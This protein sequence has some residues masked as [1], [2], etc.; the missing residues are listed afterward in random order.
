MRLLGG[1]SSKP[2]EIGLKFNRRILTKLARGYN[3][4]LVTG[5]NGKTTT[6]SMI[7]NIFRRAG[8]RVIN[9]SSGANMPGGIVTCFAKHHKFFDHS[10]DK[11]AVIEVDE[12]YAKHVTAWIK[13]KAFVITNI[14]Q[15]QIDR[16]GDVQ[17][18]KNY[19]V[20]AIKNMP[21]TTLIVNADQPI[22]RDLPVSNHCIYYGSNAVLANETDEMTT[23]FATL[24]FTIGEEVSLSLKNSTIQ[25]NEQSLSVGV[26]GF[27][28]V[29]NALCAYSVCS[30]F[31]ISHEII[32]SSLAEQ[33]S[34][35]GRFEVMQMEES[36]L[37]MLLIKNPA[38]ANQC[39]D[40]VAL[41]N[42]NVS[43][44]IML[45]DN[46]GDG[47]DISW[48]DDT[49]FEKLAKMD[50]SNVIAGGTRAEDLAKRLRLAGLENIN[51]YSEFDDILEAIKGE[52]R[53]VYA[54]V[55][56]TAMFSFRKYLASKGY[57]KG[58]L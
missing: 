11:F 25:I 43:F 12:A 53:R 6:C 18:T 50:Y 34:K 38:G 10:T 28:N 5:T 46:A 3:I 22:L 57:A 29:Y 37:V 20:D 55:S 54:L 58:N 40:T 9:N 51:V 26:P 45:N 8:L 47:R 35:F 31:G 13:P 19:I 30:F 27:Y 2:G 23:G 14:F 15:D 7:Y 1:G 39:I 33:V 44:L 21:D 24:D 41:D 36:E 56:Y 42:E 49:N 16:Y 52:R 48:I 4:I 17:V 32:A